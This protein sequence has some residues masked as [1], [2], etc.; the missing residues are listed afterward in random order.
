MIEIVKKSGYVGLF[1]FLFGMSPVATAENYMKIEKAEG[2]IKSGQAKTV[3]KEEAYDIKKKNIQFEISEF[4]KK[5]R[6]ISKQ[7]L[8]E[9]AFIERQRKNEI[10]NINE[11]YDSQVMDIEN[12]RNGEID[13]VQNNIG[14]KNSEY[15]MVV[16]N[17]ELAKVAS[18]RYKELQK[19]ITV[20]DISSLKGH[21]DE[22]KHINNVILELS[23]I[24]GI[25]MY[26]YAKAN[27]Y[28]HGV[29]KRIKEYIL[30][31][32][33]TVREM[34]YDVFENIIENGTDYE[35]E[36]MIKIIEKEKERL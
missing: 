33:Q 34:E 20:R 7:K 6:D 29:I 28:N 10:N 32:G 24:D 30:K 2:L 21:I 16:K 9:I 5:K 3:T 8:D 35:L 18:V 36:Q 17:D 11:M 22:Y 26:I 31:Q 12:L 15:D 19:Q 13:D 1:F 27:K 25:K 14:V 23:F 4:E